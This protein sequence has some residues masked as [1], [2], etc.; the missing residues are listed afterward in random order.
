[1]I[2]LMFK[3]SKQK[4]DI[5]LQ[6][7]FFYLFQDITAYKFTELTFIWQTLTLVSSGNF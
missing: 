3:I 4:I 5:I 6:T 2:W 1:M 7:I